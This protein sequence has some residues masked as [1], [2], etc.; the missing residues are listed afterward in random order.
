MRNCLLGFHLALVLQK[1]LISV[2]SDAVSLLSHFGSASS[3]SVTEKKFLRGGNEKHL[4]LQSSKFAVYGRQNDQ[5]GIHQ[6]LY[7]LTWRIDVMQKWISECG[8]NLAG[9]AIQSKECLQKSCY[10]RLALMALELHSDQLPHIFGSLHWNVVKRI[11]VRLRS[12]QGECLSECLNSFWSLN[13]LWA[14]KLTYS[15]RCCI[16]GNERGSDSLSHCSFIHYSIHA[17][18]FFFH[19]DHYVEEWESS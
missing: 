5:W 19:V 15:S 3:S 14:W 1:L 11:V 12:S 2:T 10:D 8:Y 4:E 18:F 16:W 17:S 13:T 7:I 9:S 6:W